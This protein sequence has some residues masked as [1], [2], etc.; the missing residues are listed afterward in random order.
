MKTLKFNQSQISA[1]VDKTRISTWR[2]FDEKDLSVDDLVDFINSKNGE[3]FGYAKIKEVTTKKIN[4]INENDINNHGDSINK[5]KILDIFIKYYGPRVCDSDIVKVI[6]FE[7]LGQKLPDKEVNMTTLIKEVKA[8]TDGG[9]RGNPGPSATGFIIA[10]M[11]GKTILSGGEY[12]GITT[13]NQA[14]YQAVK[15]AL[16]KAKSMGANTVHVMLDSLLVANQMNGIY[17]I[18]NRDLWPIHQSIKEL[19]DGFNKVSFTH[20]PRELNRLA[21]EQ[22]NIILDKQDKSGIESELV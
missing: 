14:E 8:Y 13:N 4:D 3:S 22:V 20:I 21:D 1:I 9:S 18:R 5:D 6:K 15:L 17:K 19:K 11:D 2:L 12:L 16:E 7:Y 10:D